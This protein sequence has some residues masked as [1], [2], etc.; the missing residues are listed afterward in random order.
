MN[1]IT[2]FSSSALATIQTEPCDRPET[3]N[4]DLHRAIQE[5]NYPQA[6]A[7]LSQG[8]SATTL[9]DGISALHRACQNGD[10]NMTQLL[11]DNHAEVNQKSDELTWSRTPIFAAIQSG[12]KDLV[13]LLLQHKALLEELDLLGMTPLF[14]AVDFYRENIALF[15][16][17]QGAKIDVKDAAGT[18]LLFLAVRRALLGVL[19][20]LVEKGATC[21]VRDAEGHTAVFEAVEHKIEILEFLFK[22]D[23]KEDIN[24]RFRDNDTPLSRATKLNLFSRVQL[25]VEAG[26]DLSFKY[27]LPYPYREAEEEMDILALAKIVFYNSP[28]VEFLQC[29]EKKAAVLST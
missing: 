12:N 3:L 25:L 14:F 11:L 20:K 21:R 27:K 29:H 6:L 7:L 19:G 22:H 2:N 10:L 23:G 15:L 18:P 9:I 13:E 8:A 4:R 1:V 24:V 26:A 16:I 5:G 17:E 28:V